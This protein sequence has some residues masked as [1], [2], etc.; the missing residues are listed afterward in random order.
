MLVSYL[1]IAGQEKEIQRFRFILFCLNITFSRGNHQK[2]FFMYVPTHA[3]KLVGL[4][5]T[6]DGFGCFHELQ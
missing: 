6:L 2:N 3:I 5:P 1:E 4:F